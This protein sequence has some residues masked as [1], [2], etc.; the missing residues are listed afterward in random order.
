L[1]QVL[2]DGGRL[3]ARPFITLLSCA[4]TRHG[5]GA[6]V[7]P[8]GD[9]AQDAAIVLLRAFLSPSG[10]L[11]W[12]LRAWRQRAGPWA[13]FR[14]ELAAWLASWRPPARDLLLLGASAGWCLPDDFLPRFRH[15]H[16]VDLDAL[17]PM[18]LRARHGRAL[19][20]T[21]T[22]LTVE[23]ADVFADLDRLLA[24]HR[25]HAVLFANLLG[26]R[27]FHRSDA[28]TTEAELAGLAA[29]LAGRAWASFHERLSGRAADLRFAPRAFDSPGALTPEALAQRIGATGEW[30]DHLTT[31][32]LPAAVPRRLMP[33]QLRSG[34]IH[35]VEAGWVG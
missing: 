9:P 22:V 19:T 8:G 11:E 31:A 2:F 20:R 1:L 32:V 13:D 18:L 33:W 17:A 3:R 25:D 6:P 7:V 4:A 27:R 30:L 5:G 21:G 10:G 28:A 16:A 14:A 15:V 12:H 26:Q 24:A 29:Q 23:R 34:R 35:W